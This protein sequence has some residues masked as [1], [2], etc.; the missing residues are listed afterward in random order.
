LNIKN[1]NINFSDLREEKPF[2]L[3]LGPY[4]FTAHDISTREGDLNAHSFRTKINTNGEI[5]WDGGMRLKP[6]S[7]YG[8][9]NIKNLK[10]P[11]LYGYALSDLDA[12]LTSGALSLVLPYQIDLE[13]DLKASINGAKLTLSSIKILNKKSNEEIINIPKVAKLDKDYNLNIAQAFQAK[14]KEQPK[15]ESNNSKPW[16]FVLKN[17]NLNSANISFLDDGLNEPLKSE[18][19]NISLH[20]KNISSTQTAPIEYKI[21]TLLNKDTQL[22]SSGTLLQKPLSLTSNLTIKNL[23]VKEFITYLTPFINFDIK[24]ADID[25]KAKIDKKTDFYIEADA[26]VKKLHIDGADGK[27]LLTWEQLD[28]KGI[29][30]AHNHKS[31]GITSLKLDSPYIRAHIAKDGTT[32]FSNLIKKSKPT[33]KEKK[34]SPMKIKIG[35]MKLVK[36][37]SDFSDFSLPFPF[38]THIDNLHGSFST[39]DFQTTTPSKL[40][41]KGKIDEYGYTDIQGTLSPFNIK[42]NASLNLLFKNID[43]NS[44]TPYSGKFVG[45]KIKSG[46]LSMDLKYAISKSKLV[47]DNKINID[48]LILGEKVDSPDAPSL[49]LEL[50]IAL[51]KDSSGQI[52]IDMPVSGDMDN[53]EFSYGG[54]IWRAV[55]NMITGIVTA[56]FKFLGSM[57]GVDGDEL[58]S[59]DFDKGSYAIIT[60]EHEKLSNLQKILSKRPSIKLTIAGGYDEIVDLYELQKQQFAIVINK[61]LAKPKKDS[62]SAQ[63]DVYGSALKEIY[64]RDFSI[65]KYNELKKSFL[66]VEKNDDNKT[67]KKSAPKLDLIAFNNQMQKN[68]TTNIKITKVSLENLANKR[69][70]SI[71]KELTTKYK[72]DGKRINILPSKLQKAKRDR[73]VEST[74][75]IAI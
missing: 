8:Q 11:K 7:V 16:Y 24:N 46:K 57:L 52:D 47:G 56:P 22:K 14:T 66:I 69:A 1:G 40:D 59:L 27:K 55:G 18:L 48:T 30:Y 21:A 2:N 49:P 67:K 26:L 36:G 19:K 32:N 53:P 39:L 37:T 31:L 42:E 6:L 33:K 73:W 72:I 60:T 54:V 23:H 28:I 71:K 75:E 51:L 29:K 44:M 70:D 65:L 64:A 17:T 5:S 45:Y 61:E 15:Q 3:E 38:S 10:L 50:A 12:Q 25:M 62:K 68:I 43:L 58:K 41:L 63:N 13:K 74:L 20:V 9:I 35:P 34:T 4:N